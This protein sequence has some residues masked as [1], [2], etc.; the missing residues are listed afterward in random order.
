MIGVQR[1][2]KPDRACD[3]AVA[4]TTQVLPSALANAQSIHGQ[5]AIKLCD[6]RGNTVRGIA[7]CYHATPAESD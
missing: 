7:L 3:R 1:D 2:R 4:L 5:H 6:S